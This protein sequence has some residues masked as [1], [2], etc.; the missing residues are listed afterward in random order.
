MLKK[1]YIAIAIAISLLFI[2]LLVGCLIHTPGAAP[3]DDTQPSDSAP[4]EPTEPI[5]PSDP[6]TVSVTQDEL[7][8]IEAYLNDLENN[9]FVGSNCYNSPSEIQL[10]WVF[11]D[12]AGIG[13]DMVQWAEGE[14][15]AVLAAIGWEEFFNSPIKIPAAAANAYLLEKCGKPLSAFNGGT[16]QDF[17]YVESYDAYYTMHGDT[18]RTSIKVE[19]G[20]IDETGHYIIR[21]AIAYGSP[22]G[23]TFTVTLRK[24]GNGFQFLSNVENPITDP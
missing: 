21:Y 12:G 24:A 6:E 7:Q 9:G 22:T 3:G 1:P 16:I 5:V 17:H 11:Y 23:Q 10:L 2:I 20:K 19:S 8:T 15:E 18:N 4:T 14:A 13:L